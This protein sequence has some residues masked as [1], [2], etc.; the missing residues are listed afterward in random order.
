[1]RPFVHSAGV[2]PRQL[3][4]LRALICAA[5]LFTAACGG[6]GAGDNSSPTTPI[7]PVPPTSPNAVT[8]GVSS[9][10]P[11]TLNV[12]A[13][14]TV[15][16]TWASCTPSDPYGY[17]GGCV[18]HGVAWDTA[19]GTDSPMQESGSYERLFTAPGSYPYHCPIHG[20]AMSGVITVQ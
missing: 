2:L 15:K 17:G 16:W 13:G 19:G 1:M 8:V 9:F 3:Q 7:P 10:N 20:A 18:T 12:A 6:G 14:T 5:A 11:G 4:S